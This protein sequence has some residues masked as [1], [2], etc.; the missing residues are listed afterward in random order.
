[1]GTTL[2]WLCLTRDGFKAIPE[3]LISGDRQIMV[4]VEGRRPRCWARKEIGHKPKFC[5]QKAESTTTTTATTTIT[6]KQA[7]AQGPGQV[8]PKTSDQEGWTEVTPRRKGS[9]KRR[10]KSSSATSPPQK[11]QYQNHQQHRHHQKYQQHQ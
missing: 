9:P 11:Q 5:P 7:E 8:Q 6:S 1:M 3:T 2:F 10:G 4:V